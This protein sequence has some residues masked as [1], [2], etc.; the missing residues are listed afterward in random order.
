MSQN[1]LLD[2]RKIKLQT[3]EDIEIY[4]DVRIREFLKEDKPPKKNSKKLQV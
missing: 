1:K 3:G 2:P 4:S